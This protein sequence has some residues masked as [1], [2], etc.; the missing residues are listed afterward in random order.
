[1]KQAPDRPQN[2]RTPCVIAQ[3]Y[4]SATV[5]SLRFR[6]PQKKKNYDSRL[7]MTFLF[8]GFLKVIQI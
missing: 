1:M 3:Q 5:V 4:S 6:S 8:Q 7:K 2:D